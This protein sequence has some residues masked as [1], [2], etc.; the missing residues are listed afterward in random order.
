MVSLRVDTLVG[1]SWQSSTV[2][3][4]GASADAMLSALGPVVSSLAKPAL[5]AAL[6]S[7]M[8]FKQP[9]ELFDPKTKTLVSRIY[10]VSVSF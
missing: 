9:L 10:I 5:R 6:S 7:G 1:G 4:S 2:Q 3:V 8:G